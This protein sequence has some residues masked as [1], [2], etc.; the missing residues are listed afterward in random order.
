MPGSSPGRKTQ[1]PRFGGVF[2]CLDERMVLKKQELYHALIDMRDRVQNL[3]DFAANRVMQQNGGEIPKWD[4][5]SGEFFND[6]YLQNGDF[7]GSGAVQLARYVLRLEFLLRQAW[8]ERFDE[9]GKALLTP[10]GMP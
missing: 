4:T 7:I 6:R 1:Q 9:N 5:S 2:Y 10:N 3:N 8:S